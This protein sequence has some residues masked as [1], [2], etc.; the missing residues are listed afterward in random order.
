MKLVYVHMYIYP[1]WYFMCFKRYKTFGMYAFQI[2]IYLMK[3][4]YVY[5]VPMYFIE[6][7]YV[8]VGSHTNVIYIIENIIKS[9]Y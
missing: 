3:C 1:H 6:Y 7:V 4:I 2:Y 8:P 5:I 9:Y